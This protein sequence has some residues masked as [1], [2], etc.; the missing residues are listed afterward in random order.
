MQK[1]AHPY[2]SEVC[3]LTSGVKEQT[4]EREMNDF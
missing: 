3:F 4:L 1:Q 2:K